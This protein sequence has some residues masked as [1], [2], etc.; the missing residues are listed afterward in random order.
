[1]KKVWIIIVVIVV[2]AI[3]GFGGYK[4]YHHFTKPAAP[5]MTAQ[6]HPAM[7]HQPMKTGSSAAA[8][9]NSVYMMK[10]SSSLGSIL[11]DPKGM[12]LYTYSKDTKGAS[13]CSS[14]C[15]KAW[16]AY[17]APSATGSFPANISVIKRTDGT[18]QYAWNGMPLYYFQGDKKAGDT[19]GN[20]IGGVWAVVKG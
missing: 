18:L 9:Q 6:T 7:N 19:N 2:V 8:A 16:P 15:L 5:A 14:G 11:T 17:V 3:V 12:T 20:G 4:L 13:N 1:M 10:T